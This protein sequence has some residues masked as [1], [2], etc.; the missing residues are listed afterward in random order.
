MPIHFHVLHF[1]VLYFHVQ[2]FHA[3]KFRP[4][5]S[6][7]AISRPAFSAPAMARVRS[8]KFSS[9]AAAAAADAAHHKK[10]R[11]SVARWIRWRAFNYTTSTC[12]D[13]LDRSGGPASLPTFVVARR[14]VY[15]VGVSSLVTRDVT[16]SSSSSSCQVRGRTIGRD[17][18]RQC[19]VESLRVCVCLSTLHD[20]QS[21]AAATPA[22]TCY[23]LHDP[24]DARRGLTNHRMSLR[25]QSSAVFEN[26]YFTFFFQ[27]SKKT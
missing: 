16:L 4:F 12:H 5:V 25:L 17:A 26:T 1:R 22:T 13:P 8:G 10:S 23:D 24:L 18:A 7:R 19:P 15:P 6:R 2:Q 27:I 3:V 11:L 14:C 21:A 20:Y 9:A